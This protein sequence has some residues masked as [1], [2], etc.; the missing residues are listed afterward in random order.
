MQKKIIY[1]I[2]LF[3]GILIVLVGLQNLVTYWGQTDFAG[4]VGQVTGIVCLIGG[5]VNIWV[6][7]NVKKTMPAKDA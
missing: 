6:A 1:Y 3:T 2:L 7:R 4:F 5:G